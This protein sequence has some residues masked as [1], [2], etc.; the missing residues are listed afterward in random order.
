VGGTVHYRLYDGTSYTPKVIGSAGFRV[1]GVV[2]A[3]PALVDQFDAQDGAFLSRAATARFGR[4]I[5]YSWVG[6]RL[7]GGTEG[8]P[9][10]QASLTRLTK[11]VGHGYVFNVRK[12]D[13]VHRQA[14]DAIRPQAVALAVFGGLAALA[15]L[16]LVSQSLAEWLQRSAGSL[17]TLRSF[18]LTRR[19]AAVPLAPPCPCW[20]DWCW[21]WRAPLPSHHWPL[22]SR[23]ASSIPCV[24]PSSTPRCWWAAP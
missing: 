10:L 8:L 15:L 2:E 13:T 12:L 4:E 22:W 18:G 9:A 14:Q 1:T 7:D 20:P 24:A 17:R 6:L 19:E 5:S 16:I 3:P 23:Y 11:E 21:P